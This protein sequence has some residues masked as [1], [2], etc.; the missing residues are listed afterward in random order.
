MCPTADQSIPR[1]WRT[2]ATTSVDIL[3]RECLRGGTGRFR[4]GSPLGQRHVSSLAWAAATR[5]GCLFWSRHRIWLGMSCNGRDQK[6]KTRSQLKH[7]LES[8]Q[9]LKPTQYVSEAV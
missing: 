7:G 6:T 2:E 3:R 4:F 8:R 5:A 9:D 1:T